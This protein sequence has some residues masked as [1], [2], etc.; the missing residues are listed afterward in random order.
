MNRP[1]RLGALQNL[2][3]QRRLGL[4]ARLS[5]RSKTHTHAHTYTRVNVRH[6]V[7]GRHIRSYRRVPAGL[8]LTQ[9]GCIVRLE[10]PPQNRALILCRG[11]ASHSNMSARMHTPEF[12]QAHESAPSRQRL[13]MGTDVP[14]SSPHADKNRPFQRPV[15]NCAPLRTADATEAP[16]STRQVPARVS[17]TT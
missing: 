4:G 15:S 11:F 6:H 2:L 17:A 1:H 14:R 10:M 9:H 5:S 12:S 7:Q 3:G 16:S 13:D 8:P